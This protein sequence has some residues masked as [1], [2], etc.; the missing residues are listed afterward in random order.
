MEL[1]RPQLIRWIPAQTPPS[2]ALFRSKEG[3]LYVRFSKRMP[4]SP[5]FLQIVRINFYEK[6]CG[7]GRFTEI[8][9]AVEPMANIFVENIMNLRLIPY[10]TRRGYSRYPGP[11]ECWYRMR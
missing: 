3:E 8:L 9:D 10:L 6:Y 2:R 5:D 1:I 11:D 7:Q 4:R